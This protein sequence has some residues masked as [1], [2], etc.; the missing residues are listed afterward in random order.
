MRGSALRRHVEQ[1]CDAAGF[2]A[3]IA[4][5]TTDPRLLCELVG[6][7][8]GVTI[9]PRSIADHGIGHGTPLAV[10]ELAP[11]ITPRHTALAWRTVRGGHRQ[12]GRSS[13]QHAV[14][15]HRE[16]SSTPDSDATCWLPP[17][18]SATRAAAA[19]V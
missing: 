15:P 19:D 17:G 9:V 2:T 18:P 4:L 10:V 7:G 6:H 12:L 5:E 14:G 8:L 13:R 11:P 3:H 1:A 16:D